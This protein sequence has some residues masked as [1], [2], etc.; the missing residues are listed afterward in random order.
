MFMESLYESEKEWRFLGKSPLGE[1]RL[2]KGI[3]QLKL[4]KEGYE[5]KTFSISNPTMR[6]N[7]FP[8]SLPWRLNQLVFNLKKEF[9]KG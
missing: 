9:P 4:E 3:I 2:P 7:N 5:T 8:I 6:L 1:V